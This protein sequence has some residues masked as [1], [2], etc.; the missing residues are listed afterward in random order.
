MEAQNPLTLHTAKAVGFL[1]GEALS[2]FLFRATLKLR[3]V[4]LPRPIWFCATRH[5]YPYGRRTCYQFAS[6]FFSLPWFYPWEGW[7]RHWNL[8]SMTSTGTNPLPVG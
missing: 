6:S 5:M 4:P 7:I 3:G 1:S 2:P 8:I